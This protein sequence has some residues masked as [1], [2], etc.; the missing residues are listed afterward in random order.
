MEETK[1]LHLIWSSTEAL[2]FVQAVTVW[3]FKVHNPGWRVYLWLVPRGLP[4][5]GKI[6]YLDR[7]PLDSV[8]IVDLKTAGLSHQLSFTSIS[9]I[10][11]FHLLALHG[12][13]YSDFDVVFSHSLPFA[14]DKD[15][16][17]GGAILREGASYLEAHFPVGLLYAPHPGSPLW[18]D[19]AQAARASAGLGGSR[20][21]ASLFP[22]EVPRDSTMGDLLAGIHASIAKHFHDHPFRVLDGRSYRPVPPTDAQVLLAKRPPKT[23][24]WLW[25]N[26]NPY[27]CFAI[28]WFANHPAMQHPVPEASILGQLL[29]AYMGRYVTGKPD[30]REPVKKERDKKKEKKPAEEK[31][32]RLKSKKPQVM[33]PR[34]KKVRSKKLQGVLALVR[35]KVK[36]RTK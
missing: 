35:Q 19:L 20:L 16:V 32:K 31:K 29:K 5:K 12:G 34:T 18:R 3:S 2:S 36:G 15:V 17:F 14:I 4:A 6:S 1:I 22:V 11:R 7:L 10:L 23:F 21:L 24:S 25:S 27:R 13:L 33:K 30:M 26:V 9:H 8:H 28:Q